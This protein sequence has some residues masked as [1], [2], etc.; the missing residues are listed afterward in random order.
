MKKVLL[1]IL[2]MV[3]A[4]NF[5]AQGSDAYITDDMCIDMIIDSKSTILD[6]QVYVENDECTMLY[7]LETK[8]NIE[9][10]ME[11]L[12]CHDDIYIQKDFHINED[13]N[14]E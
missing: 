6:R 7:V 13:G 8:R 9:Y 3:S 14:Y 10:F 1:F 5:Y 12:N 2:L 4:I 11:Y